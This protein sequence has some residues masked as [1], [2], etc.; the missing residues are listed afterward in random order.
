MASVFLSYDHEDSAR[1]AP[2]AAALEA[3]GHSVWW[4]RHIHGG[5]EYNSAIEDAVERSDAV[6]V[7]WSE[8]SVR[9]AWVR[10]E[11]AEGRDAGKL[12]P[13]LLDAVKPPMGFRQYQTIDLTAWNGGKRIAALPNVLQ[14]IEKVAK[15]PPAPDRA[16]P[17]APAP[18]PAIQPAPRTI[19]TRATG[20]VSRRTA[21]AGASA[22][23]GAVA[24][25]GGGYW[26]STH[27]REDPRVQAILDAAEDSLRKEATDEETVRSLQRA[28]AMQPDNAQALGLLALVNSMLAQTSD[29]KDTPRLVDAAEKAARQALSMNANEPSALLAMF[30]LQGST[31]DW[32]TRDQRLRQI[33]G[34]DPN[35]FGA[36]SELVLLTQGTGFCRESYDWNERALAIEPLSPD[37]LGR[38]AM[39]LWILGR[40][41][42]ADK[43]VD[44]LRSLYPNDPWVGFVRFETYVF[45]GRIRAAQAMLD[46]NAP[47]HGGTA[48]TTVWRTCLAALDQ[49][50]AAAIA[51]AR[52]ACVHGALASP[53]FASQ[54]V[55]IMS[56]LG[57]LNTAF[58][59]ANGLLLSEGPFVP[60]ET[61]HEA[62][63]RISTQW[64]FTPPAAPLRADPRFLPL[65]DDVGITDYWRKRGRKPDYQRP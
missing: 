50:S 35:N 12:V 52:E 40:P 65:C 64:M 6:I 49:R 51:K 27:R 20:A 62:G 28:V 25:A 23:L 48:E 37:I 34:I 54:A 19:N 2:L 21:I 5:A 30:E 57:D 13:I 36:I 58:D 17:P 3:H 24:L 53:E 14:A 7:L 41:S 45:T 31:L 43:V 63:W 55:V 33:I 44:Q 56:T 32:F 16:P 9:S 29:D 22:A 39:K 15:P 18:A 42:E 59:I 10:D 60:R 11:A 4:D 47:G 1:A 26:W 38:R 46:S 8:K 61:G